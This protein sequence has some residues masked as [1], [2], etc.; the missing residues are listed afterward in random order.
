VHAA[1]REE[2]IL[3]LLR[4]KGFVS[5]Q[6]LDRRV[7]ASPATLRRDLGR[8]ETKGA[9]M[10]VRGGAKAP[11][12]KASSDNHFTGSPFHENIWRNTAAKAAI[13][14]EAAKLCRPGEAIIID[15]GSTTLQMCPHLDGLGLQVLTNSLHIVSALMPQKRTQISVP[16]GSVFREQNIVLSAFEDDGTAAYRA[17]R[18]FLGAASVGKHGM[19]QTDVL[20]LQA[21]RRLMARA[22][23]LVLLVDSTKFEA[24]AGQVVCPLDEIDVLV[25]DSGIS[26][27][28]RRLVKSADVR[29]IVVDAL[30][31]PKARTKS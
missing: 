31:E 10:R 21:E 30:P 26:A 1:E 5:F 19:R 18:M 16:A 8:L 17:S 20:L 28:Q 2:L 27:E 9:I 3:K 14:K 15:G 6:E 24:A 11:G 25:T 4:D 29:L 23:E 7:N 13:G 12:D 22:E